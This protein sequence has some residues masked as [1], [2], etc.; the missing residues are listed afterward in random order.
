MRLGTRSEARVALPTNAELLILDAL[1]D[2]GQGTVEDVVERLPSNPRANYKT[3]Q[4]LLRIME[5]KGFV[6][7]TTHGRAFVFTPRVSRDG[8][9]RASARH[10]LDRNFHGSYA[11]MLMNLLDSNQV[12]DQ[13]L[14]ELEALIQRYRD[15]KTRGGT[16]K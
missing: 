4:S 11:A 2:L 7:H 5:N 10:V 13:E 9:S 15:Q 16:L 1:W 6:K 8:V 3:I 12:K 14:D